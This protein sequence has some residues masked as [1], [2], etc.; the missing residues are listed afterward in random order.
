MILGF[1]VAGL[2]GMSVLTV[3]YGDEFTVTSGSAGSTNTE[4]GTTYTESD[5]DGELD[6]ADGVV[7]TDKEEEK[8]SSSSSTNTTSN[9]TT[10]SSTSSNDGYENSGS[11][12]YSDSERT[13]GEYEEEEWKKECA[14]FGYGTLEFYEC[15]AKYV[16]DYSVGQYANKEDSTQTSSD[17]LDALEVKPGVEL[18]IDGDIKALNGVRRIKV[19][20]REAQSVDILLRRPGTLIEYFIGTVVSV[21][22]KH[23]Y[24]IWN[25]LQ[26][27]NGEYEVVARVTNVF[28]TYESVGSIIKVNNEIEETIQYSD[29]DSLYWSDEIKEDIAR[30]LNILEDKGELETDL[31]ELEDIKLM[32]GIDTDSDGLTDSEEL[33][34]GTNRFH[35]DTDGDG[36]LD[37]LEI[38]RGFNPLL[39]SPGDKVAFTE[40]SEKIGTVRDDLYVIESIRAGEKEGSEFLSISGRARPLVFVTLY[41][42]S[43]V[44]IVVT[45]RAD[46]FGK[47]EYKLSKTIPDGEHRVYVALADTNGLIVEKSNPLFFVKEAQAIVVTND[48][49]EDT[50]SV[51]AESSF[52][53]S[54]ILL[55]TFIVV[56]VAVVL[57]AVI[58]FKVIV[59][60][61]EEPP[62]TPP[63]N[64]G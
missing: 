10:G 24:V 3:A 41:I 13:T 47:F 43:E 39:A 2:L 32:A 55:V 44:P 56:I 38:A 25:T 19:E 52:K 4:P 36:Y 46:V 15:K 20:V 6:A 49:L 11:E 14:K 17:L 12:T 33:R 40:P 51:T 54:T 50:V 64:T 26:T 34:L 21:D 27:P 62:L 63:E 59:S 53:F 31:V 7:E 23:G 61:K 35:P 22:S 57:A 37:G 45:V 5:D 42:Y 28:G 60:K 9:N 48:I 16:S 29:D 8:D 58:M 30:Q 1:G 18:E